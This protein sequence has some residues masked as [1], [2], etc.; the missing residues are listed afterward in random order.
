MPQK[1]RPLCCHG[2]PGRP[3]R[4]RPEGRPF[5]DGGRDEAAFGS[6]S[7]CC[8]L[9]AHARMPGPA[10]IASQLCPAPHSAV[11]WWC[12]RNAYC[13]CCDC[14]ASQVSRPRFVHTPPT[15]SRAGI[16]QNVHG[17]RTAQW[18]SGGAPAY[19]DGGVA[20]VNQWWRRGRVGRRKASIGVRCHCEYRTWCA[21][22]QEEQKRPDGG[23]QR[24]RRRWQ[25]R[26]RGQQQSRGAGDD[27]NDEDDEEVRTHHD[28]A[29]AGAGPRVWLATAA[30]IS[31]KRARLRRRHRGRISLDAR[32]RKYV[33][34][35]ACMCA[36]CFG[37]QVEE[38]D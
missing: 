26:R 4:C 31:W 8:P 17:A 28:G 12:C 30:A 24:W 16:Q 32:T 35:P 19:A 38:A 36:C 2:P 13:G 9:H 21:G 10:R 22:P 1:R 23:Q 14:A 11:M 3:R 18:G 34:L 20:A 15:V 6:S 37:Y 25:R 29:G 27:D 5:L 7:L 33:V